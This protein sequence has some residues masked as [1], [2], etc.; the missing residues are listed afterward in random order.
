MKRISFVDRS[1]ND[2]KQFPEDARREAGYQL[3]KVQRGIEPT[4]WKPMKMV[5]AGVTE[6]RIRD[7]Q[8]IYRVIYIS[9]YANTVFVLHAFKK[10]SQKTAKKDLEIARKRLKVVIQEV[11]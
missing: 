3:D 5:G 1:L 10:K 8:G 6:I 7:D 11:Q 9:K 4:D 2:L